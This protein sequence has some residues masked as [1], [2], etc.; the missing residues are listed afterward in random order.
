MIPR[1]FIE[2]GKT[3]PKAEME[4]TLR[5]IFSAAQSSKDHAV[6]KFP[7]RYSWLK[8]QL[9]IDTSELPQSSC[10]EFDQMI[11]NIKPVS[12][13]VVFPT[14]FMNSP[15]SM[16]GHT[17][18]NIET[19]TRSPL[20]FPSIHYA[21][22]TTE[23][24]GLVFALKGLFGYYKGYY[25]IQPYYQEL[26]DYSDISQRDIWE[27]PLN[28]R[29]EEVMRLLRHLWE[30]RDIYSEYY[31]FDENC[32]FN[33]LFLIEAAVPS[34]HLIEKFPRW[35]LP[36][37]MI[38][39]TEKEHLVEDVRYRPSKASKIQYKISL[40]S[41][42]YQNIALDIIYGRTEPDTVADLAIDAEEK[43]KIFDLSIEY[44]QYQYAK[45][46]ITLEEYQKLLLKTLSA[47]SRLGQ[48]ESDYAVPVPISPDESHESARMSIG[49]G[50]HDGSAYAELG[51][52][53]VFCDM[54]DSDYSLKDGNQIQFFNTKLRYYEEDR[55]FVLENLSFVDIMSVSARD[56]FFKPYSWKVNT[57]FFRRSFDGEESSS[58]YRLNTGGGMASYHRFR[59]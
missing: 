12:A 46:Q 56:R 57:G 48:K 22:I 6:C 29:K 7:G 1:F 10:E 4:A 18:I 50:I 31:F 9:D 55:K 27:Y 35:T 54:S 47:R 23:T 2:N 39:A 38:R 5:A 33:L 51:F 58:L 49:A 59:V 19:E 36:I 40:L 37:D 25:S 16:F 14:Y 20:L 3:D 53:P 44:I 32:S 8:E 24:N 11:D 43:I 52:R 17:M 34:L 30:I 41:E 15:A 42:E 13:T 28:L 26:Q 21:A 45:K